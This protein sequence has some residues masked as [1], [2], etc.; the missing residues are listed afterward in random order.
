MEKGSHEYDD[1]I[2]LPRPVSRRH[3]PMPLKARA[4]Q[5]SPYAALTGYDDLI[6]ESER[7]TELP[8]ELTETALEELD[9]QL[10]LLPERISKGEKSRIRYYEADAVKEGGCFTDYNGKVRKIDREKRQ[11]ILENGRRLCFENI[12][13]IGEN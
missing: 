5:F 10:T 8:A 4:A 9:R 12:V 13:K 1:I 2:G 7:V 6:D 11:L 3:A